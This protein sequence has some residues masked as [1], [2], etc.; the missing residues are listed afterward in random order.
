MVIRVSTKRV[1]SGESTLSY[2]CGFNTGILACLNFLIR[3]HI[4]RTLT[5]C[6]RD[7]YFYFYFYLGFTIF[8]NCL[9][10]L[11]TYCI[12]LDSLYWFFSLKEYSASHTFHVFQTFSSLFSY[13]TTG[14]IY[15]MTWWSKW[16]RNG[17][18]KLR[19]IVGCSRIMKDLER[20]EELQNRLCIRSQQIR[21]SG[22]RSG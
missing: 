22:D 21:Y 3:F 4:L 2:P 13:C 14:R 7:F 20:H 10:N 18:F 6:F 9:K 1:I 16:S 12:Y 19:L 15:T 11:P 8:S 5:Y 17:S